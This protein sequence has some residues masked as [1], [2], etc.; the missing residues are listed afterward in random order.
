MPELTLYF[1]E[2]CPYSQRVLQF[3]EDNNINEIE[4]KNINQEAD[5]EQELIDRGGKNQVPCLLIDDRPLYESKE[6]VS[7][8]EENLK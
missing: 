8:L 3:L 1:V 7:W 5:A 6:I 4:L 2:T